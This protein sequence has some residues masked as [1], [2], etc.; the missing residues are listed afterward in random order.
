VAARG[1]D[2]DDFTVLMPTIQ[3]S[4]SDNPDLGVEIRGTEEFQMPSTSELR[5]VV[6]FI[7]LSFVAPNEVGDV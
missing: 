2:S 7:N 4:F 1:E 6:N 5:R 3:M